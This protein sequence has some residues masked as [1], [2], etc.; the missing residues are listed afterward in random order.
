MAK[1]Y[2]I[3]AY[4]SI[5]DP[6]A[7]AQYAKLAGPALKAAGGSERKLAEFEKRMKDLGYIIIAGSA[8]DMASMIKA[9]LARWTPIVKASG[10]KAE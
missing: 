6:E 2:W 9:E 10:A 4:R 3:S 5:S 8:D 7:L 1:A